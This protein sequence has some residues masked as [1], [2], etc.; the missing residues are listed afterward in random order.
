MQLVILQILGI[1]LLWKSPSPGVNVQ[2]DFM[3]TL[4]NRE[5]FSENQ[6][7]S[8][9]N[10]HYSMQNDTVRDCVTAIGNRAFIP[11]A[12]L[13]THRPRFVDTNGEF[14]IELRISKTRTF[15]QKDFFLRKQI[16]NYN[17]NQQTTGGD[18]FDY[19]AMEVS[20]DEFLFG[21]FVW[22]VVVSPQPEL[23]TTSWAAVAA[24]TVASSKR[25]ALKQT[26]SSHGSIDS[27]SLDNLG[28]H[29]TV[30]RTSSRSFYHRFDTTTNTNSKLD[31]DAKMQNNLSNSP[32]TK[33]G[34]NIDTGVCTTSDELLARLSF[35]VRNY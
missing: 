33:G 20:S 32:G 19:D 26:R 7:F 10:A 5:R 11:I 35:Q 3:V 18:S 17:K 9:P 25:N 22:M 28:L 15:F 16:R 8:I 14:Q 30:K 1:S 23:L 12:E 24:S 21:G 29:I 6:F 27:S 34:Y 13:L 4:L 31:L 2:V